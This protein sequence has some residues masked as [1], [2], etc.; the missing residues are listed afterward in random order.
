MKKGEFIYNWPL[1]GN[2]QITDFLERS[3]SRNNLSGTFIFTGPDNLGKT[4]IARHFAQA[5]LCDNKRAGSGLL[6]CGVCPSCRRLKPK[7][8]QGM[9]ETE[10]TAE[11]SAHGDFHFLAKAKDKKNIAIEQVRELIAVLSLTSFLGSYKIGIIKHADHLSAEAA[12]ALLKTLEEPRAGVLITLIANN[13]DALPA[14]I[15][16][17]SQVLQFRPVPAD[18]IYDYLVV[19]FKMP[20]GQAKK[21]SRLCLGRPALAMKFSGNRD[22]YEKYLGQARLFLDFFRQDINERFAAIGSLF[23]PK[24]IGQEAVVQTRRIL[25][26]WQGVV[27]DLALLE[28]HLIDLIQHELLET[29]L[30]AVKAGLPSR[31][32]LRIMKIIHTAEDYL[33]ANVNPKTVL[34]TVAVNI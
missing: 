27:R 9:G 15:V 4:T 28:Y 14:T 26:V 19:K 20:R 18:I 3:I 2:S 31:E 23:A 16:S 5:L 29:E 32:I 13:L 7:T 34:E 1:V 24:E 25:E 12:N 6:P 30:K 11:A 21:F 10:A 22:F 33:R 8:S 17:R